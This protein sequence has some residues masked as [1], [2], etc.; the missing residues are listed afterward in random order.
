M[1]SDFRLLVKFE[2]TFKGV[3]YVH[4]N[5]Q[6][7]NRVADCL[8]DDLYQLQSESKFRNDVDSGRFA[9][10]PKGLVGVRGL[11]RRAVPVLS[12]AGVSEAGSETR[13][14][15]GRPAGDPPAT[16]R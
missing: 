16:T 8:F 15:V 1:V 9:L 12:R 11:V 7:G 6:L 13:G 5:S 4:R 10:N 2:D 14:G 3:R